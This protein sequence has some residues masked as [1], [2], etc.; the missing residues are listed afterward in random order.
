MHKNRYTILKPSY[1][2][3]TFYFANCCERPISTI[4]H[5]MI[6]WQIVKPCPAHPV[7]C[8]YM[9]C[10]PTLNKVT[11]MKIIIFKFIMRTVSRQTRIEGTGSR[12]VNRQFVLVS[13]Q[14]TKMWDFS[15]HFECVCCARNF[16]S[17]MDI[18]P[19][20]RWIA[21]ERTP[22]LKNDWF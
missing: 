4:Q 8:I 19:D 7:W 5:N 14:L 1:P 13:G 20:L 17:S 3:I 12:W 6:D 9:F 11:V 22:V 15:Q 21:A 16:S 10:T 18:V 2:Y